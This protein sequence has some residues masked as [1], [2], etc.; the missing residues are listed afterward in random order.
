MLC[1]AETCRPEAWLR[2]VLTHIA[3]QPVHQVNNLWPW[4][5]NLPAAL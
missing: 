2:H 5:C 3:D 4:N 1:Q